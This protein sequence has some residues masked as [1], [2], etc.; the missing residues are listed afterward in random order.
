MFPP[1]AVLIF[2]AVC[3]SPAALVALDFIAAVFCA[4]CCL[5]LL[6]LFGF[7]VVFTVAALVVKIIR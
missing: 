6:L 4:F 7:I 3:F 5:L 2:I 1:A